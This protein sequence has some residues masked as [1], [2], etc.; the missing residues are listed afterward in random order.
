MPR[1]LLV[2]LGSLG[3]A[4]GN[5]CP[6]VEIAYQSRAPVQQYRRQSLR[7][8]REVPGYSLRLTSRAKGSFRSSSLVSLWYFRISRRA[9][10]PG[11]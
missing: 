9:T 6:S 10:V 11:R 7:R 4:T 2:V 1:Q 3:S 8:K 5:P